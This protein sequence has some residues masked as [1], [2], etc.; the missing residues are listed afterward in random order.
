MSRETWNT[1]CI[2]KEGSSFSFTATGFMM[3]S[4]TYGPTNVEP[5][6][7]TP[8][9]VAN[10]KRRLLAQERK[11]GQAHGGGPPGVGSLLPSVAEPLGPPPRL[12]GN[13]AWS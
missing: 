1:G 4:M 5:T 3:L 8:L 2:F 7:V 13:D 6:Y 9:V 10:L 11:Q 12:D